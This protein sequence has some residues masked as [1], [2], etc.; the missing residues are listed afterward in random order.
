MTIKVKPLQEAINKAEAARQTFCLASPGTDEEF[1]A[2][3]SGFDA[4]LG[5]FRNAIEE[6][7]DALGSDRAST[8][9]SPGITA[10]AVD[11]AA[12]RAEALREACKAAIE[13]YDKANPFRT[14]DCHSDG[15]H[16]FRCRMDAMRALIN[17]EEDQ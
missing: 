8:D 14:A 3:L 16:C 10:G 1:R 17:K 7:G 4:A 11:P 5:I 12:I 2:Y 15:C 13:A 6:G 9:T